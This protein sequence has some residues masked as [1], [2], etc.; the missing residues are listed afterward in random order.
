[1]EIEKGDSEILSYIDGQI[2]AGRAWRSDIAKAADRNEQFYYMQP[3]DELATS[4]VEGRS[5]FVASD[6]FDLIEWVL[7]SLMKIFTS[8]DKAVELEPQ[9]PED[10]EGAKQWTE[11]LNYLFYRKNNGFLILY[12]LFKEA[13]IKKT[14][15][16][17]VD[18]EVSKAKKKARFKA[19]GAEELAMLMEEGELVASTIYPGENG[20]ELIDAEIETEEEKGAAVVE[21]VPFSEIVV[22]S[23]AEYGKRPNFIA[24][25]TRKTLTEIRNEGIDIPDDA[26]DSE[27]N[28]WQAQPLRYGLPDN[29]KLFDDCEAD[30]SMRYTSLVDAYCHYDMDGDGIAEYR[31]IVKIG[32]YVVY[33][34]EV[35]DHPFVAASP[36]VVPGQWDGVAMA[37]LA[38]DFQLLNTQT[39]RAFVDNLR[40]LV[41]GRFV[42]AR[43]GGV[44]L[45]DILNSRPGGL[46]RADDV[47]G[48]KPLEH[49]NVLNDAIGGIEFFT[50]QKENR[51]GFTRY[52][53]GTDS[54]SLN[55]TATGINIITNK[56]DARLELV[57]RT[58]A[59]SVKEIFIK[60]MKVC[61]QNQTKEDIFR[62]N[63]EFVPFDPSAYDGQYDFTV[64]VGLGTG[65]KDQ[66]VQHLMMLLSE[67][68]EGIAAGYTNKE[69]IVKTLRRLANEIGFKDGDTYFGNDEEQPNEQMQQAEQAIEQLK[70]ML[71]EAQAQND[72]S[73]AKIQKMM[74]ESRKIAAEATEKE[75]QNDAA[76]SG[77]AEAIEQ[78]NT[79]QTQSQYQQILSST[80]PQ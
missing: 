2:S 37:D 61:Q 1:M 77:M 59:E 16:V 38:S 43:N 27:D 39:T 3:V 78:L 23:D 73:A 30:P 51:T 67:Q 26:A 40:F 66:K 19:I 62:L 64:N 70:Q 24:H 80:E 6:V 58:F 75:L 44:D 17:R 5:N 55:K 47:N 74:A 46:I 4:E 28:D 48:V 21:F 32:D 18:W 29:D 13:L 12:S 10:I 60:L 56:A 65:N 71:A 41:N 33:N 76:A 9:G 15:Y 63:G 49:P 42:V 25:V 69:Q 72:E 53:Q 11:Y 14:G 36:I 20:E 7:P 22:S 79:L 50:T 45:A 34:E 31:R 54:N 52:S 35:E 8:S 57:A 68:K